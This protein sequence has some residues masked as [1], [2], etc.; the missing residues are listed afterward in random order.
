MTDTEKAKIVDIKLVITDDGRF[1][2]TVNSKTKLDPYKPKVYAF[3]NTAELSDFLN[4]QIKD[5]YT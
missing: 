3:V 1:V 5:G 2:A 4:G